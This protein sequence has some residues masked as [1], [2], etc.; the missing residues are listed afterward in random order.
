M[1]ADCVKVFVQTVYEP[2][3]EHVSKFGEIEEKILM[4]HLAILNFVN[5]IY[6][7]S[8]RWKSC[9]VSPIFLLQ[10]R[11]DTLESV[12]YF[13]DSIAKVITYVNEVQIYNICSEA[14]FPIL[15]RDLSKMQLLQT[16]FITGMRTLQELNGWMLLCWSHQRTY[17]M[18]II[19]LEILQFRES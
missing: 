11:E 4:E 13:H 3:K 6:L 12:Q 18:Y 9:C 5:L 16:L 8:F 15:K 19:E 10:A 2:Y 14:I 1:S 17:R 7:F